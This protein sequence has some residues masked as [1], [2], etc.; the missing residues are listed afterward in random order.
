MKQE[1]PQKEEFFDLL[2]LAVR[3]GE[4]VK[5]TEARPL[6]VGGLEKGVTK[7]PARNV[8]A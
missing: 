3:K 4:K 1:N 6:E 8:L 2:N 7:K 5:L